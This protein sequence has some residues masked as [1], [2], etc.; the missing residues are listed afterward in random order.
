MTLF[1]V[2]PYLADAAADEPGGVFFRPLGGKNRA[3][4]GDGSYRSLYLGDSA[5]GSIAEAFGRFDFWDAA[6]F[7]TDG[8]TPFLPGSR[9]AIAAYELPQNVHLRD[10]DDAHTL[11]DEGLRPSE[12]VTRNRDV[13]QAWARRIHAGGGYAGVSWWSYYDAS[14][15]SLALWDISRLALVGKPRRLHLS[16]TTVEK[17]ASIIVRRVIR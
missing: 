12:V 2:F 17:A 3:D 15:H 11:V 13:T 4:A 6:L 5:E 14:W 8:A 9:F 10:L 7:E 1:R 16:D